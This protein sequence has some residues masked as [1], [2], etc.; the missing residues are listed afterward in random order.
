MSAI[1]YISYDGM[2]DPLGQSQVLPY[3]VGLSQKGYQIV[4]ISFEKEE[5]FE[6]N[7]A[8]IE[9]IC[10]KANIVWKP[11]NYTKK[12][13][14]LSTLWDVY[15]LKRLIKKLQ[16]Q[17]HFS[18]SHCRSHIS[19]MGGAS[20]KRKS[21]VPFIFDMRGFYADERVDGNIWKLSN[22]LFRKVYNFFKQKEK[23]FLHDAAYT[24]S[25]TEAGKRIIHS[26]SGFEQTPIQVIPCCADLNHFNRS[27]VDET[28]VKQWQKEL[29]INDD[30]FVI[31]YLG[32]LG[33][34]Y[35]GD[36]MFQFFKR[37]LIHNP[38][39]KFLLITPDSKSLIESYA[40]KNSVPK[41]AII[42]K[43]AK[44]NEVPELLLLS[45]LALFFIKP[46][47]S[48]QASSPVKM[49]EIL[50]M[51]I[52][53]IANAGVGDVDAII[54]DTQCGIIVNG[55]TESDFDNAISQIDEL[56]KQEKSVFIKASQKYYSLADGVEKYV[57]V[58]EQILRR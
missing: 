47:F 1:L 3:L 39:A 9:A 7:K 35:M 27:N 30:D 13:P 14:I 10:T 57:K 41:E 8:T 18:L 36:E 4:L 33:T 31:S 56:L 23:S 29:Q 6:S 44:R 55:F 34:W 2:T 53:T 16:K 49:G 12:P 5:R 48:K 28:R 20:L 54:S 51:G 38:K 26:W 43:S 42:V 37:L 40:E 15:Q 25:L 22:P 32:S 24:I 19:S 45:K 52:P 21:N 58:Y 17:Y 50:A 46:V 11:L